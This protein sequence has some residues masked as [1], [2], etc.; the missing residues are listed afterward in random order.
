[1]TLFPILADRGSFDGLLFVGFE[2]DSRLDRRLRKVMNDFSGFL[3][4]FFWSTGAGGADGSGAGA[5][6]G[7]DGDGDGSV[8]KT[9][10]R[11]FCDD[12]AGR[13]CDSSDC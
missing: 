10:E 11:G 2:D 13:L 8:V 7:G 12:D 4:E 3:C 6:A 1:M 5:G 9:G